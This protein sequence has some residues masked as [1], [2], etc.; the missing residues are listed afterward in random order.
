MDIGFLR[1]G[2][3]IQGSDLGCCDLLR[4]THKEGGETGL[5]RGKG[6]GRILEGP[7][8]SRVFSSRP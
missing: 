3:E 2:Q 1:L 6:P 7:V 8:H 4:N 5:R